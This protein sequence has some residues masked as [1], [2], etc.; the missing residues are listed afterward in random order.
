M[1]VR[2]AEVT[3]VPSTTALSRPFIDLGVCTT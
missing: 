2:V 3:G 1:I